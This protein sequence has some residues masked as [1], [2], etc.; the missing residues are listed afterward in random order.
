M[1]KA[2]D[3]LRVSSQLIDA[4]T[5]THV[6]ADRYDR[7]ATDLFAVQDEITE[8]AVASIEP[9]LYAA[10]NRR[11]Q[12][13]P[14][15]SIDAWGYVMRAMPQLW[16]WGEREIE[17]ALTD[18]KRAIAIEPDYAEFIACWPG[19]TSRA[20]IW[21]GYPTRMALASPWICPPLGRT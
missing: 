17:T 3:R 19:H 8:N 18:L 20:R 1:R 2:G 14:L 7:A 6:W 13:K 15:E 4:N 10:E 11:V 12:N 16:T 21:A 5:G 9:Q